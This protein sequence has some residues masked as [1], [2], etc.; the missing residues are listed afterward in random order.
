MAPAPEKIENIVSVRVI[1]RDL[2]L[3]VVGIAIAAAVGAIYV[4]FST[5]GLSQF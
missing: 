2:T 5:T 3:Y 1:E 4:I